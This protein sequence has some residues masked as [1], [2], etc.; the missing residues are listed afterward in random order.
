MFV[1]QK[2]FIF[3]TTGVGDRKVA[4]QLIDIRNN[5]TKGVTRKQS[6]PNFPKNETFFTP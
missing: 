5:V 4:D 1:F 2:R 6:T 3:A